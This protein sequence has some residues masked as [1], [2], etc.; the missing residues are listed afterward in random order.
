MDG[1]VSNVAK[2]TTCQ[3]LNS[4]L[5]AKHLCDNENDNGAP[6]ATSCE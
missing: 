5:F 2:I 1:A 3:P 6:H 4:A